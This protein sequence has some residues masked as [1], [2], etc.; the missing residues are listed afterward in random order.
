MD[1][2]R[3]DLL[4]NKE[5]IKNDLEVKLLLKSAKINS[6]IINNRNIIRQNLY[7]KNILRGQ[8]LE[9]AKINSN[10]KITRKINLIRNRQMSR[11]IRDIQN[12]Y[13]SINQVFNNDLIE[14]NNDTKY[15]NVNYYSYNKRKYI[16]ELKR[17]F[18]E[19][20]YSLK[21]I[22]NFINEVNKLYDDYIYNE[23]TRIPDNYYYRNINYDKNNYFN[24]IEVND[25][26]NRLILPIIKNRYYKRELL[27]DHN[28]N[29]YYNNCNKYS[30]K[31]EREIKLQ[32]IL[33]NY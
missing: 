16:K 12:K 24:N 4:S 9:K 22:D 13:K 27:N 7:N 31:E 8:R 33:E 14:A 15:N 19:K 25:E 18:Y 21:G 17:K 10:F 20:N 30:D 29:Y 5:R 1:T 23:Q 3:K 2:K 11:D 6:N 32:K 28:N 26:K